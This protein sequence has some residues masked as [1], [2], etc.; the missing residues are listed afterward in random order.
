MKRTRNMNCRYLIL[1]SVISVMF[2]FSSCKK[3][4]TTETYSAKAVVSAYLAAGKA[5]SLTVTEE[6]LSG[7]SDTTLHTIDNLNI[8]VSTNGTTIPLYAKGSGLYASDSTVKVVVG[9]AYN[10]KF[11]YNGDSITSTTIIPPKPTGYTTSASTMTIPANDPSYES[12]I[13]PITL[14]WNN[15]SSDYYLIAVNNI[16]PTPVLIDTAA[17]H[18]GGNFFH[19][20]PMQ[21]NTYQLEARS[22]KYYGTH[23]VILYRINAEYAAIYQSNGN[24]SQT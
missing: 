17:S 8:I 22:F 6:I 15:P 19:N 16:E 1:L 3:D 12:S 2:V 4:E 23:D 13:T 11:T 24:N 10:L 7:S 18:F 20:Q 5:I 9:Q 14:S 21:T